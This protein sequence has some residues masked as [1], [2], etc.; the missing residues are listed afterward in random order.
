MLDD[1]PGHFNFC[2]ILFLVFG[3][4]F[5]VFASEKNLSPFALIRSLCLPFVGLVFIL[6]N[7]LLLIIIIIVVGN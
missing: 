1:F 3:D 4:F 5:A 7:M 2:L 6:H